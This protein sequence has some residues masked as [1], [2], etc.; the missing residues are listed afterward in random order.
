MKK[1]MVFIALILM[2]SPVYSAV[3]WW[4]YTFSG[5]D[6]MNYTI[7]DGPDWSKAADLGIYSG[8]RVYVP[9]DPQTQTNGSPIRS[10]YASTNDAF[11]SW[12]NTTDSRV[13]RI[14]LWGYDGMATEFG[15]FYKV[16]AWNAPGSTV[17]GWSSD[18][19]WSGEIGNWSWGTPPDNNN[20]KIIRW[21]NFTGY[22]N[23]FGFGD[24]AYPTFTFRLG[25]DENDPFFNGGGWYEGQEGK[26]VFWFGSQMI[27][28]SE[29][30]VGSYQG[31]FVLQGVPTNPV[32]EPAS[33][34]LYLFGFFITSRF[35]RKV[36]K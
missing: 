7:F 3:K 28:S 8:A 17:P 12:A 23:L 33:I 19:N 4:E 18:S 31:N 14:N 30:Y 16:W 32:P 5:E 24:S 36:K 9:F 13:Y 21:F 15:E 34:M 25:L 20:G 2:S 26:L 35:V 22:D 29:Q 27:N 6:I 11:E 1:Y 10:Y